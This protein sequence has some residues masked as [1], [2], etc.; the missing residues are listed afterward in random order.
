M[1]RPSA[2]QAFSS[3]ASSW[4]SAGRVPSKI[5]SSTAA[6]MVFEWRNASI[7][8][9]TKSGTTLEVVIASRLQGIALIQYLAGLAFDNR[10]NPHARIHAVAGSEEKFVV[11]AIE[12]GFV[13]RGVLEQRDVIYFTGH[14]GRQ[15]EPVQ[16]ERQAIGNVH[17]RRGPPY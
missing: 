3:L 6:N 12:Q 9:R 13:E 14:A 15:T 11:F 2:T 8:L 7:K 1:S 4:Y 17:A 5:P 10:A 16:I